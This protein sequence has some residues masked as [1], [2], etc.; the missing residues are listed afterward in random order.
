MATILMVVTAA[1]A[2]FTGAL[3]RLTG[4]SVRAASRP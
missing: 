2:S 3:P 4:G 1:I